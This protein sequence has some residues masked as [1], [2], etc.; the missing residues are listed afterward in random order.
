MSPLTSER[1]DIGGFTEGLDSFGCA[2]PGGHSLRNERGMRLPLPLI[3]P[4]LSPM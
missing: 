3:C 4:E 2:G 1:F